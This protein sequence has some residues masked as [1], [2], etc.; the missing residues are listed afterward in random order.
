MALEIVSLKSRGNSVLVSC[1]N[2]EIF[3]LSLKAAADM[4]IFGAQNLDDDAEDLLRA[5]AE[6]FRCLQSAI[7]CLSRRTRSEKEMITYLAGK[8]FE[9]QPISKTIAY[10]RDHALL[11]DMAFAKEYVSAALRKQKYGRHKIAAELS[12]KGIS[13]NIS[14][15]LLPAECNSDSEYER[16]MAAA[17]KKFKTITDEDDIE[18]KLSAFL[19]QRGFDWNTIRKIV[20]TLRQDLEIGAKP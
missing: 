11:D 13:K 17:L 16:G 7:R 8:K 20:K 18:R 14:A 19:Q 1:S 3:T 6:F 15:E 10:M 5:E 12:K 9:P 2:G 4:K